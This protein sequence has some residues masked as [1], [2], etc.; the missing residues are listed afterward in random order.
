MLA[1]VYSLQ[2]DPNHATAHGVVGA[3]LAVLRT[4][5]AEQCD[6]GAVVFNGAPPLSLS[7]VPPQNNSIHPPPAAL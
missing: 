3:V 4:D 2:V 5:L 1:L 6:G 7:P